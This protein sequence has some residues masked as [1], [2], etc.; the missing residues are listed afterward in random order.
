MFTIQQSRW[1]KLLRRV[2]GSIGPG[3]RVGTSISDL[4]PVLDVE[5]VPSELLALSGTRL[6]WGRI[7]PPAVPGENARGQLFNP[8]DSGKLITVTTVWIGGT[9]SGEVFELG[10]LG[11]ALA[12]ESAVPAYRDGRFGTALRG[13]A[14]LRQDSN[15]GAT[16]TAFR[17][18][19]P[20]QSSFPIFDPNDICVLPPGI[21][22]TISATSSNLSYT[23]SFMWRERTAELSELNF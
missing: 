3:S 10:L 13:V 11:V 18:R 17:M 16:P 19:V 1:D 5:S 6:G 2:S 8:E 22:L 4:F 21:G 9:G 23:A 14:E 20:L 7:I 15:V 12:N